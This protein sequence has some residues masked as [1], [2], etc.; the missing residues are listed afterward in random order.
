MKKKKNKSLVF[1]FIKFMVGVFYPRIEI[2][3]KENLPDKPVV[4]VGNHTQMNGPIFFLPWGS[5]CG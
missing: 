2:I 3:G 4:I 1:S 5:Y